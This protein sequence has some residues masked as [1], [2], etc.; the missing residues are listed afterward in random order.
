[1]T[2]IGKISFVY[3]GDYDELTTYEEKDC[4]TYKGSTFCALKDVT[5]IAPVHDNE[6]WWQMSKGIEGNGET[7]SPE[8]PTEQEDGS[9]WL[10]EY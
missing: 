8:E 4:V 6:N 5:G 3:K 7:I 10:L 1:M 2:D 9:F